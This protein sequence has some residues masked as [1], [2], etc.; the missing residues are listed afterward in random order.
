MAIVR[1]VISYNQAPIL[2]YALT[3]PKRACVYAAIT[4]DEVREASDDDSKLKIAASKTFSSEG[5]TRVQP[6]KLLLRALKG[7]VKLEG[8]VGWGTYQSNPPKENFRRIF[9]PKIQEGE[10]H[11]SSTYMNTHLKEA[12]DDL[13]ARPD[14]RDEFKDRPKPKVP[15]S[16]TVIRRS[17]VSIQGHQFLRQ[18]P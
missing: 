11:L 3:T 5:T 12:W 18:G 8:S 4:L 7:L 14:E 17:I 10:Y 15:I 13:W 6:S 9:G 1:I 2:W 16:F